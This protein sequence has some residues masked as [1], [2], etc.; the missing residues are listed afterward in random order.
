MRNK[1]NNFADSLLML[2]RD[3]GCAIWNVSRR[4]I[5]RL[6]ML[7]WPQLIL[8][9]IG[10]VFVIAILHLALF[11]FLF[12]MVLKLLVVSIVINTRRNRASRKEPYTIE[13]HK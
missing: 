5:R 2:L 6:R 12:F 8:A 1:R 3:T 4:T 10:L 9:C 13:N 11:L 7:S